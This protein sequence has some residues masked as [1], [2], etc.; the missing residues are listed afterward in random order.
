M[1]MVDIHS[2][3]LWGIDDGAKEPADTIEMATLWPPVKET[4]R[5]TPVSSTL[6]Y[7]TPIR[8]LK[9]TAGR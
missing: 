1:V 3:I 6:N 7:I 2:H 5:Y 9:T 8:P 4:G